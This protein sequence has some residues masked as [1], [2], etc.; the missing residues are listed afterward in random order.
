[1]STKKVPF[2][3]PQPQK[4]VYLVDDGTRE[5]VLANK[6]GQVICKL[7]FRATDL[8]IVDRYNAVM[9]DIP[10]VVKP[11]S[12][13]SINNDG[14]NTFDKDWAALKKVEGALKQKINR[15]LDTDEADEIFASR[16]PFSSV[17]GRFF[18]EVV[19]EA[20]GK[21]VTDAAEEEAKLSKQ[22]TEK[23]LSDIEH[24]ESGN[25]WGASDNS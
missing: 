5:I 23:F 10:E 13:I 7:H 4:N 11:L 3:I 8:S 1:M 20:I 22:R 25:A 16:N 19:L 24:E 12:N 9:A 18:V 14:T 15:L 6:F 17:G 21:A 2:S